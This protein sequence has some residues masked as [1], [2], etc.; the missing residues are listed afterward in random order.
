MPVSSRLVIDALTQRY[1][2]AEPSAPNKSCEEIADFLRT[3]DPNQISDHSLLDAIANEHPDW[4][5]GTSEIAVLHSVRDCMTMIF[6]LVD[7]DPEITARIEQMTSVVAAELVLQPTLPLE[8]ANSSVLSIAD[9]LLDATIGWSSDQGRAGEKLLTKVDEVVTSLQSQ[10]V[11]F[12]TLQTELSTFL[13]KDQSR[14]QKLEDRLAA[15]ESGKLRSQK[16]R[17][18][19]A[20]MINKSMEGHQ[21]T[22]NITNFLKGP[23]YESMQLLAING[24]LD[25]DDWIRATKLTETIIW[26]YQ[27]I[28]SADEEKAN[29]EKQRLYRIVENLTGEIRDL[30][31]AFEHNS[32]NLDTAIEDIEQDHIL[33]VSGQ[34]LEYADFE[35]IESD[36]EPIGQRTSV[37][38]I[39]L[40]KVNNLEPGQW[41]TYDENGK[42]ARIKLVLKL[43]D[44]KQMLFTN[45]N[46]MKALEKSY[47]E[48]AYLMSSSV[49]KPLN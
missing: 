21:L 46:G 2:G 13:G 47:D 9:K 37:S 6:N 17:S 44:V 14:I 48:M 20:E 3:L 42:C 18:L 49:I 41:F 8:D 27:P 25:G 34:E 22:E 24:G 12:E 11:D 36:G 45:R 39:L 35:P 40:R 29:A 33:M 19:A 5:P 1:I 31:L 7:L 15:S 16:S 28:T 10:P 32:A 38:R 43:Q 30:L 26:T 23:W 4:I